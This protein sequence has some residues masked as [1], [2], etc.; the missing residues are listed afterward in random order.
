MAD[1]SCNARVEELRHRIELY[2]GFLEDGSRL[3]QTEFYLE[4]IRDSECELARLAL[5]KTGL[6]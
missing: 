4:Q 1:Q 3:K 5:T 6:H 2:R